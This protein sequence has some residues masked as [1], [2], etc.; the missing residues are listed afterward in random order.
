LIADDRLLQCQSILFVAR[1]ILGAKFV[2]V[3]MAVARK[4]ER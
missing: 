4:V 1:Q 3:V 2:L